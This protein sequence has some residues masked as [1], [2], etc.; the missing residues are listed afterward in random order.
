MY[1]RDT[2]SYE[3]VTYTYYDI[4]EKYRATHNT[5]EIESPFECFMK[6]LGI[7]LICFFSLI[8]SFMLIAGIPL[9]FIEPR[10]CVIRNKCEMTGIDWWLHYADNNIYID[11]IIREIKQN[12]KSANR[13][14]ES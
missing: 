8:G 1:I 14:D 13:K 5:G 2:Y 7:N 3:G 11:G 9:M 12:L 10:N 4:P 6:F